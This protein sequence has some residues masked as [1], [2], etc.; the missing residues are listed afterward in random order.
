MTT[1]ETLKPESAGTSD[2]D[3]HFELPY[4]PVGDRMGM[5]IFL[6]TEILLFGTL[7]IAYAVY[8]KLYT[9][10]FTVGSA[11]LSIA[12][13]A[14]NT[15]V[16]LTSSLTVALAI[17]AI[18]RGD[19]R[20]SLKLL[21]VTL[22]FALV[23]LVIKSFEWAGKIQ[24]GLYPGSER[25]KDMTY[26]E[27]IFY[28]LYFTMTGFHALHVIIGAALILWARVRIEKGLIT[29]ERYVMLEN[30]GLYWHLVDLVWIFLF[31][32]FYLI[33]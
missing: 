20:L 7:F 9:W 27:N 4:D 6:F 21:D 26:G 8:L 15:V 33:H 30:V 19:K 11:E 17:A 32:L 16:L 24:H 10:Q 31:P 2:H 18:E 13:G 1:A 12:M 3:D 22:L 5:W 23:F 29:P 14:T 25:L 28:S